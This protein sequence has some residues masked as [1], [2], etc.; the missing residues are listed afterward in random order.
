MW[1]PIFAAIIAKLIGIGLDEFLKW[2]ENRFKDAEP[3]LGAPSGN[4]EADVRTALNA[5]LADLWWFQF[6]KRKAVRTCLKH[7]PAA[8][9]TRGP[10]PA[11]GQNEIKADAALAV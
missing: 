3:R 11:A 2:L 9:A 8:V 7:V 1:G 6:A 5:V 10:I 4:P